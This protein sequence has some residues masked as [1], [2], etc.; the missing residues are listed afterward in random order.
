MN[1][2]ISKYDKKIALLERAALYISGLA[3]ILKELKGIE[4][5]PMSDIMARVPGETVVEKAAT[6]GVSRQAYY[7]WINGRMRPSLPQ[8]ERIAELT[9]I[10]ISNIS[11]TDDT[12]PRG[13]TQARSATSV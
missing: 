7:G 12:I 1:V 11:N 3:E 8:A 10:P 4:L 13:S 9:G 2:F 6:I 5:I